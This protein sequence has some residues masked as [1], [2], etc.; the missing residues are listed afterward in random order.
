GRELSAQLIEVAR[1]YEAAVADCLLACWCILL[2]RQSGQSELTVS[3]A[4]DG[5]TEEELKSVQGLLAKFL[6]LQCRLHEAL[7]FIELLHQI[8][9]ATMQAGAWQEMFTWEQAT[10]SAAQ[11]VAPIFPDYCFDYSE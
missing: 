6:P 10:E 9:E 11:T 5:R 2:W 8:R 7:P 1:R 4:F 3:R